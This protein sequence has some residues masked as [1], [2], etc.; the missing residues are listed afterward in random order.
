MLWVFTS[1]SALASNEDEYLKA[2]QVETEKVERSALSAADA[3]SGPGAQWSTGSKE[4]LTGMGFS[5]G[6]SEQGFDL[7]LAEKY[8]GSAVFYRKLSRRNQEEIYEYYQQGA[9]IDEVRK[10]IVN[11]FLNR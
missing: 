2:I 9:S 3:E 6:L 11:R 8:T 7:E 10:K 1:T 4:D 5:N